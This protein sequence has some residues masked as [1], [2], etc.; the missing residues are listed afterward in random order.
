MDINQYQEELIGQIKV[1]A[2]I[3]GRTPDDEF[4]EDS[5]NKLTEMSELVDPFISFFGQRGKQNKMMVID[6]YAIDPSDHAL[7]LFTSKF[8]QNPSEMKLGKTDLDSIFSRMENF[9]ECVF[10]GS[11]N[12]Y[13]DDSNVYVEIAKDLKRRLEIRYVNVGEEDESIERIRLLVITNGYLAVRNAKAFGSEVFHGKKVDKT[14]WSLERFFEMYQ[15]G[16]EREAIEIHLADF[17]VNGLPFIKAPL[18]EGTRYDGY[19]TI[20]PGKLLADIYGRYGSRILESN[21][22][23]FLSNRK[24]INA[25]IRNT[26]KTHPDDFFAYNNGISCTTENIHFEKQNG[27]EVIT[28]LSD[29]QIINGGQTTASLFSAMSKE[30]AD[31]SKTFVQAKITVIH[32]QEEY[33]EMVQNIARY[34]NSQNQIKESDFFANHPFHVELERIANETPTPV[35]AGNLRSH[36]WYY[37]RSRGKYDQQTFKM[38]DAQKKKYVE[39][40]PKQ[41]VI[42]KEELAQYFN[43]FNGKPFMVARGQVKNIAE[44]SSYINDR[45]N[46]DSSFL[47]VHFFKRMVSYAILFRRARFILSNADWYDQKGI[48]TSVVPYALAKMCAICPKGYEIDWAS[49]WNYQSVPPA[50][51]QMLSIALKDAYLFITSTNHGV[52]TEFAKKEDNW[53][54]YLKEPLQPTMEFAKTLVS[55][56]IEAEKS[57]SAQ[58]EKAASE[59]I[60]VE[61]EI[62]K[63]GGAYWKRIWDEAA[64]RRIIGPLDV[65]LLQKASTLSGPRP[66]LLNQKEAKDLWKLRERLEKQGVIVE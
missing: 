15:S 3:N 22:R 4:T 55:T 35:A 2:Q 50:V 19:L 34:A 61:V 13:C 58:K 26:I 51:D 32:E 16:R 46:K 28:S 53:K 49:I 18:V 38:T 1:D 14:V 52:F 9:L 6:G 12:E 63:L 47:N 56:I 27:E 64:E 8:I 45:W 29:L 24:K 62:M 31:L 41:Q 65:R 5:V 7:T 33:G 40:H 48:V 57:Y 43:S 42:T 20:F 17:G 21:I 10:E 39:S 44:F 25:G 59:S 23:A 11:I 30:G 36:Y 37:E 60:N 66:Q 54:L